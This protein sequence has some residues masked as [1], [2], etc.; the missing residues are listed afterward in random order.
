[1]KTPRFEELAVAWKD[2]AKFFIVYTREAHAN[3]KGYDRLSAF[4]DRVA[5]MDRDGDNAVALAEFEGPREMFDPFDLDRDEVIR[6][7][8]LLAARRISQFESFDAPQDDAGRVAA[9]RRFRDEVPG[10][11]PVLVDPIGEPTAQAYGG[12]PNSAFV[13]AE[14]GTI[15]Q[16][17]PWASVREVEAALVRITGRKAAAP[18]RTPALDVLAPQLQ[19]ARRTGKRVLVQFTAPG[20]GACKAMHEQTLDRAE[21]KRELDRYER[22][23]LGVELDPHWA[24]FES[25]DLATTPAFAVLDADGNVHARTQG[26]QEPTD[27]LASLRA[28]PR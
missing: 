11:I 22:V 13:I 8:E 21:V 6:S 18:A 23:V 2:E 15:A 27:F 1:M 26:F 7:H 24:L 28:R 9:V 16:A 5:T 12:M 10:T 14:D 4:A 3:A 25:L 20:C 19:A 17:M